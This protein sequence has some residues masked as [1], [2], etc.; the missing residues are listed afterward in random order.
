[1]ITKDDQLRRPPEMSLNGL[2]RQGQQGVTEGSDWKNKTEQ[3]ICYPYLSKFGG[4]NKPV[5]YI[6]PD[7]Y[8]VTK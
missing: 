4:F 3:N 6:F 1:M 5:I 7:N 8:L 2:R